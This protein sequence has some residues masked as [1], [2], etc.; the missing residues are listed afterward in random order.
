MS[1]FFPLPKS[2]KLNKDVELEVFECQNTTFQLVSVAPN[3]VLDLHN[4]LE[5]QMG[6]IFNGNLEMNFNGNKTILQ[7]LNH[8]YIAD[9]NVPHGSINL[10]N[11]TVRCFDVKRLTDCLPAENC[12]LNISPDEDKITK[13]PC[14]SVISNWFEIYMTKIPS[15]YTIP[16][17]QC[18]KEEIGFILN[19]K[20]NMA[21]GE[22]EKILEYGKI[23]YAPSKVLHKG[24]NSSDEEVLLIK[25]LI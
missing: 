12:I 21:V 4:H 23:Y 3:A 25:I 7:P 1:K 9:C 19:G 6:M 8:V 2:I 10:L 15:G 5:S 24:S 22:E 16:V 13:L 11:E 14:Q 20:L 18:D 17:H